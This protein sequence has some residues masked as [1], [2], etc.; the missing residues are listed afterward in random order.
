MRRFSFHSL[1]MLLSFLVGIAL[2]AGWRF[3]HTQ[4]E[5][6]IRQIPPINNEMT[7]CP[8]GGSEYPESQPIR[9]VDF[10]NFS[11]PNKAFHYR[12]FPKTISLVDGE[13]QF[14][15]PEEKLLW[16]A[17]LSPSHISYA[18]LTR[19]GEPEAILEIFS[20]SGASGGEYFFYIYTMKRGQPKLL[21]FFETYASGSDVGGHRNLYAGNGELVLELNG[22]NKIIGNRSEV[23]SYAGDTN[24]D[25]CSRVRFRWNGE[26]FRQKGQVEFYPLPD[27]RN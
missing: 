12:G 1:L 6:E 10:L 2:V 4:A 27:K 22:A 8:L 5:A 17:S 19:D 26:S 20:Q 3:L 16:R 23:I 14:R 24:Y 11:Y 18:D 13:F 25:E 7:A 15:K 21:W 9:E